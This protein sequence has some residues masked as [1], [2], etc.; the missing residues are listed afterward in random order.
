MNVEKLRKILKRRVSLD[1]ND[2]YSLQDCWNSMINILTKN[3]DETIDFFKTQCSNEEFF[4]LSEIFEDIAYKTQSKE[5]ITVLNERLNS[6]NSNNFNQ[7]EFKTNFTKDNVSFDY[8]IQ[9]IKKDI[10]F[11]EA[12]IID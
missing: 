8:F 9:D 10:E 3:I 6:I 2:D 7:K 12:N 1:I 11:A 4:W 5:F